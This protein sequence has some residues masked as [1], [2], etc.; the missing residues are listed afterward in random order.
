MTKT[1]STAG[2]LRWILFA[3]V[4]AGI[5]GYVIQLLA[6]VL[7]EQEASYV[8]FSVLWSA[9]YL[10]VS[11]MSGVQQEVTRAA[12][13]STAHAPNTVLRTF[14][15][16]AAGVIMVVGIV[17]GFTLA[18]SVLPGS[19]WALAA[20]LCIAL[21]GYLLIAVL[22]G[23]MY[24]LSLWRAVAMLTILDAVIRAIA[25]TV[26]F[27]LQLPSVVIAFGIAFPFGLT[28]AVVWIAVRRHVV[29]KFA[30]DVTFPALA[31]NVTSTVGAAICMGAMISGLPLLIGLTGSSEQASAI[32]AVILAITL[33]RAP[34]VIPVIALQSFLISAVF[35]ERAGI[36]RKTVARLLLIASGIISVLAVLA[37]FIGPP[38]I[39]LVS[40]GKFQIDSM[41][42]AVIVLS[43]GLV[44]MMC[45]T[46]PAL[47]AA[48]RHTVNLI[49]WVLAAV[50]TVA[51]LLVPLELHLK[52]GIALILPVVVGLAVHLFTL[53]GRGV[54]T[55]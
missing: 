9:V 49:G 16:A 36:D 44:A 51:C 30:L 1:E 6:P 8:T 42:M 4:I 38:I 17:L 39:V 11:A 34:I 20:A 14:T 55:D 22:S 54:S 21:A 40:A 41:M 28:A 48:R 23:V 29:G 33:S 13:P 27:A 50:L 15:I 47:V 53:L 3:T 5:L 35:R 2:G 18:S 52:V 32:G 12:R 26:A 45:V 7:L 43:A 25:L 31:R 19:A 37:A 24:G 10:C 46:G